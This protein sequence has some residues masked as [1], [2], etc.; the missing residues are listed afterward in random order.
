MKMVRI[1]ANVIVDELSLHGEFASAM[2]FPRFHGENWNAWIDCM[3]HL[4]SPEAEMT[5]FHLAPDEELRVDLVGGASFQ[6]RCPE[7]FEAL[8]DCTRSV[9]RRFADHGERARV[10]IQLVEGVG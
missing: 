6:Q 1:N 8:V 3:S 10:T 2:G 4:T 7:L 5:A 9:N